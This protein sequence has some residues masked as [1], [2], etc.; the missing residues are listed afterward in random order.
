MVGEIPAVDEGAA[1]AEPA[2]SNVGEVA[3]VGDVAQRQGVDAAIVGEG[4]AAVD[5]EVRIR[6]DEQC[7]G[8]CDVP[9][10]PRQDGASVINPGG[11]IL[12]QTDGR[13]KRTAHTVDVVDSVS[14]GPLNP[15]IAGK[16]EHED[17]GEGKEK[18]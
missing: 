6:R 1:V 12:A 4:G 11:P 15:W 10:G 17:R 13:V 9:P 16:S 7:G 18:E 5:S 14:I 8:S 3:E 2:E